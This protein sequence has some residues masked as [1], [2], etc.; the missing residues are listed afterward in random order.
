MKKEIFSKHTNAAGGQ[1]RPKT[2]GYV[3]LKEKKTR[4]EPL[5]SYPFNST[6]KPGSEVT[7]VFFDKKVVT[8]TSP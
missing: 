3:M 7:I 4:F 6:N 5:R 2:I 8:K 1:N